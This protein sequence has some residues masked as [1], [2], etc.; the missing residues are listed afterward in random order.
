MVTAALRTL[1]HRAESCETAKLSRLRSETPEL[2]AKP[3]K[4]AE[5]VAKVEGRT[6]GKTI[7]DAGIAK[8]IVFLLLLGVAQ[9][10]VCYKTK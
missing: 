4:T 1:K 3:T 6:V 10:G 5:E 7:R 8:S 9:Y 2:A